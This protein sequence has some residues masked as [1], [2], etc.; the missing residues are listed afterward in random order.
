[1]AYGFVLPRLFLEYY[2]SA[3]NGLVSSI[4]QFLGF[5]ALAECGIG[6]VVQ[7]TLYR[8]LAQNDSQ[9]I[10][11]IVISAERFFKGIAKLLVL[12]TIALIFLYPHFACRHF[13]FIYTA[14]L[15]FIISISSFAQYYFGITYRLLLTADQFG[16]VPILVQIAA[17]S[18]NLVF[19]IVLIHAGASIHVVKFVSSC[20]FFL[21]P[22]SVSFIARRW[23]KIDRKA[24]VEKNAIPQKWNGLA[25]HISAVVLQSSGVVALTLFSTLENV[26]VYAIYNLVV[27]GARNLILSMTNGMQAFLG[28]LF[29]KGDLRSFINGFENFERKIHFTVSV[30]FSITASLI[31]PFVGVYTKGVAD[32]NYI[33]PLFGLVLT[34]GWGVYCVRLPY[35]IVVLSVGHYKQ[36][37]KSAII[38]AVL[39]LLVS[40]ILVINFGVI[41]VA[42]GTL[43]AMIY[44]TC[45]LAWYISRNVINRSLWVFFKHLVIDVVSVFLFF[46][47]LYNFFGYSISYDTS[48]APKTYTSWFWLATKYSIICFVV[49]NCVNVFVYWKY[50]GTLMNKMR[51][52]FKK[53]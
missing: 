29:S 2:G 28:N 40:S 3:V 14:S 25:Q 24:I 21:Q 45:Y 10:S 30:I 1:M 13:N 38:E 20:V 53:K 7:S 17:L 41:G 8:P 35:N 34:C 43:I 33:L 39:N 32:V 49:V 42:F 48:T 47:V 12:Y 5:I 11:R 22:L 23:Y 46:V 9:N 18:L 16:F 31:V 6:A 52:F 50:V 19:S 51:F 4:T 36:T 27:Q 26:S 15:V 37:Q 44:R